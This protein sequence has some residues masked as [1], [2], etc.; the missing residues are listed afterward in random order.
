[1]AQDAVDQILTSLKVISMIKEGQKV[2]V[3]NGLLDLETQSSGLKVGIK[4]WLNNDNRHT[5]LLYVKNS[6][7]NAIGTLKLNSEHDDKIRQYLLDSI[8]GLNALEITYGNDASITA[9][10]QVLQERIK[11]EIKDS[12]NLVVNGFRT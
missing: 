3:R 12:H 4:R 10:L 2:K 5:T 9:S 11:T 6:V 8:N 7:N 1:M